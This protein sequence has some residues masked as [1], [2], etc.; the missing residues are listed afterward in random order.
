MYFS[1]LGG[2]ATINS[3]EEP[4]RG[5]Q[6]IGEFLVLLFVLAF[7]PN[8]T[9][10]LFLPHNIKERDGATD[11]GLGDGRGRSPN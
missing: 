4:R 8:L 2:D 9:N 10:R 6:T 3:G 7:H 5:R 1:K 11:V